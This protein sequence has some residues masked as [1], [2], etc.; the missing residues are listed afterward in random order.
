M[1]FTAIFSCLFLLAAFHASAQST[2]TPPPYPQNAT[3]TPTPTPTCASPF[4]FANTVVPAPRALATAEFE[5]APAFTAAHSL[6]L[7]ITDD[8]TLSE[9]VIATACLD[10]CIAY[11]ANNSTTGPCLSFF[12]NIGMP[13]PPTG[14]GGPARWFCDG[15]DASLA[16]DGSDYVPVGVE[17]SYMHGLGVNRVCNGTYRAY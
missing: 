5:I 16:E 8:T 10:R 15:Y 7:S 14:N 13:I 3:T 11:R 12:V 9:A 17:G 1:P 4:G 2:A 6:F